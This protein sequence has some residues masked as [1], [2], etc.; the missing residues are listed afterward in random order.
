MGCVG[1]GRIGLSPASSM[2]AGGVRLG[3]IGSDWVGLD[4]VGGWV[5]GHGCWA[6][7]LEWVRLVRTGL[8]YIGL[9]CYS[10]GYPY[11][12]LYGYPMVTPMANGP[13]S[14]PLPCLGS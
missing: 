14:L 8:G 2:G 9:A 7:E 6:A 3:W 12:H 11:E 10:Y 5:V 4:W 13:W 1:L